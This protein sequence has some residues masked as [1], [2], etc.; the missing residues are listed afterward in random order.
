M[1]FFVFFLDS[2]V[3]PIQF[4]RSRLLTPEINLQDEDN[5][6]YNPL[7]ATDANDE[8]YNPLAPID[9]QQSSNTINTSSSLIGPFK[10]D[11]ELCI[12]LVQ[13]TDLINL[14]LNMT[15]ASGCESIIT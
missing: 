11:L 6:M 1:F 3:M 13:R 12:F 9:G 4:G 15:K 7:T 2:M 8:M 5:E 10:S 14:T